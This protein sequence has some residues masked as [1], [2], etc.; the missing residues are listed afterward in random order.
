[1]KSVNFGINSK[2]IGNRF[3]ITLVA[4][5]IQMTFGFLS[6]VL[7]ARSLGPADYGNYSFLLGSIA[8]I[9]TLFNMGTSSAFYTFISNKKRAPEF[10]LYYAFWLFAQFIFIFLLISFI[11]PHSL[12]ERIWLGHPKTLILFAFLASFVMSKV[13]EASSQIGESIRKTIK[14][15]FHKIA[16]L[17]LYLCIIVSMIFLKSLTIKNIFM[18]TAFSYL[19]FSGLLI[20]GLKDDL[21]SREKLKIAR[22]FGQFKDY[23]KPLVI[24]HI[25]TFV[26]LFT[27][28]WLLQ[29]FGGASQQGFYFVGL[30]FSTIISIFTI[31]IL[32]VF[33][34]EIAETNEKGGKDRLFMLYTKISRIMYFVSAAAA[35][36]FIP[37][38]KEIL[39]LALGTDYQVA[40]LCLAIMFLH[41]IYQS[42]AQINGTYLYATSQTRLR[43][44]IGIGMMITS[45]IVTYFILASPTAVI[46]G[47][48]LGSIGLASKVVMFQFL[49]GNISSYL[50]CRS[51]KWKFNIFYQFR[52]IIVLFLISLGIK[53]LLLKCFYFLNIHIYPA[54]LMML[55][56]FIYILI[57][58]VI[59]YLFPD[60]HGIKRDDIVKLFRTLI[61]KKGRKL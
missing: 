3:F 29:R 4:N 37:F 6:G 41:P 39:I 31:S 32:N 12:R 5:V 47:L 9:V 34:K 16:I 30:R 55:C 22:Y 61:D 28:V 10:Y 53:S 51:S 17:I 26:Y 24:F 54:L 52:T 21:F 59:I 13:W 27:D 58:G 38:S 50:I 25:V 20:A 19:L 14:V 57:L 2:N 8:S 49:S 48:N 56:L 46:P 43:S 44:N 1:M 42:F 36:F 40:W 23:C 35:C 7:I 33:W 15:Q 18:A 45:V 11:L 60:F